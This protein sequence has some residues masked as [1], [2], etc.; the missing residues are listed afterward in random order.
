MSRAGRSTCL[1]SSMRSRSLT[2]HPRGR[3]LASGPRDPAV[4]PSGS[5]RARHRSGPGVTVDR[6]PY[7]HSD[8]PSRPALELPDGARLAV[9]LGINIERYAFGQ[10]ALSLVPEFRT[11]VPDPINHGWRDYGSRVGIWRLLD[12]LRDVGVRGTALINAV[13][14]RD[15]PELVARLQ[16][17]DWGWVAHGWDN[18]TL[19]VGMSRDEEVAYLERVT[20]TIEQ[21]VGS[22]PT[23][24]L[25]PARSSSP[26]THELLPDV[27]YT[28]LMDWSNDDQPYHFD[29]PRGRLA[30]VPYSI[31][32]NDIVAF[33][34]H[35]FTGPEFA[36]MILDHAS[37]LYEEADGSAR[38]VGLS[39][40]PFLIGQSFRTRYLLEAIEGIRALGDDIWWTTSPE[41][42]AWY[43]DQLPEGG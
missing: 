39:L 32:V 9:W 31:E 4:P 43:L 14:A 7:P 37:C 36:Q 26:H 40:H 22:R 27:G 3:G 30:S 24:W 2:K 29:V 33:T 8:L 41:I 38:V 6:P 10:P 20:T 5:D 35:G 23:G 42:A 28:H 19:Q 15:H 16:D 12:R 34:V 18:S 21:S 13:V 25:G 17:D 1:P 11:F